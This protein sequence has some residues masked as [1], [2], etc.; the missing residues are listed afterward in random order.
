[1]KQIIALVKPFRAQAVIE[2]I[3][4]LDIEACLITEAKGYGRQKGYL[5]RYVGSEYSLAFLPKVE[6]SAW[7]PDRLVREVTERIVQAARTGRIGDGKIL[8]LPVLACEA[9][10][11]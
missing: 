11:A 5:E 9:I 3:T 1:M 7:V 10:D 4:A 2:A 8:V 6:I